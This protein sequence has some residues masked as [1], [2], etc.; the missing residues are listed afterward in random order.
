MPRSSKKTTKKTATKTTKQ[1]QKKAVKK[2]AKKTA[3]KVSQRV[4]KKAA[5][6][7]GLKRALVCAND[8]Q[9]FWV[10]DGQILKNLEELASAL[11]AMHQDL[12][13][14]HAKGKNNDFA[15]WVEH[16]L[17]DEACAADL[18]KT[19]SQNGA[20]KVVIRHLSYY[21]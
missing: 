8:E 19:R 1:S 20:H 10:S 2:T 14:Y 12:F 3:K 16:V 5:A 6:N 11:K 13:T 18:R 9:C 7:T 4:T 17:A 15:D 21:A